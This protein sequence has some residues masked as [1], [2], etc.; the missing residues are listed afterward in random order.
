MPD[1]VSRVGP[2]ADIAECNHDV[3]FVPKAD[4]GELF[5]YSSVSAHSGT[6]SGVNEAQM[7]DNFIATAMVRRM[8]YSVEHRH[9]G[10]IKRAHAL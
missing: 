7:A 9:I 5:N 6:V 10:K 2:L 8:V 3:R 1:D 4:I